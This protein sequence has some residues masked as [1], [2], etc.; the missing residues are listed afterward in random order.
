VLHPLPLLSLA[1]GLLPLVYLAC[2]VGMG[3]MMFVMMRGSRGKSGQRES[4]ARSLADIKADHARLAA[5]VER[6]EARTGE[7]T[8]TAD[9]A[10]K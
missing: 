6:L 5:E 1:S 4:E 9:E 2:P 7:A 3:A 8:P 10:S